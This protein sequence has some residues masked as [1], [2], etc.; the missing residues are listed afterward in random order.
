MKKDRTITE[1][2]FLDIV[3]ETRHDGKKPYPFIVRTGEDFSIPPNSE[4]HIHHSG[5][6]DVFTNSKYDEK[7]SNRLG[8]SN[9]FS[10]FITAVR[11]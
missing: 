11:G 10:T 5:H 8:L 9:G 1:K 3:T 6:L 4:V 7:L 2:Q